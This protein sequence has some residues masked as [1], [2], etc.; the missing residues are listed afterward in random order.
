MSTLERT[1]R[2][3]QVVLTVAVGSACIAPFALGALKET[4]VHDG[5]Q[6]AAVLAQAVSVSHGVG[7][8][9]PPAARQGREKLRGAMSEA[10][11]LPALNLHA[12]Y[13]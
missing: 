13:L 10:Q 11:Y 6:P 4:D 5:A 12:G 8:M 3:A 9:T 2:I 7:R 1:D